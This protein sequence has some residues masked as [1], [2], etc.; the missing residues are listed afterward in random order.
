MSLRDLAKTALSSFSRVTTQP[1]QTTIEQVRMGSVVARLDDGQQ[2]QTVIWEFDD[3]TNRVACTCGASYCEH[4]AA[5]LVALAGDDL[6]CA[7]ADAPESR[8]SAPPLIDSHTVTDE[9]IIEA[10]RVL[11]GETSGDGVVGESS[12]RDDALRHTLALLQ[13]RDLPG[14]R[15]AVGLLR[16]VITSEDKDITRATTALIHITSS[17]A[18]L[19]RRLEGASGGSEP[20]R[21]RH[22]GRRREEL[23]LMEVARNTQRTPFGERRDISYFL[24]LDERILLRELA[25][26]APGSAPKMSE[27]PFP[28]LLLGNLVTIEDGPDPKRV[29]LLQYSSAGY[30]TDGDFEQ[31]L[32]ACDTD[33]A[34]IYSRYSKDCSEGN[35]GPDSLVLYAPDRVIRTSTGV[36]FADESGALLPLA[37]SIAPSWCDTVDLISH[38]GA[39]L[40]VIGPIVFHPKFLTL[41]P[42]SVLLDIGG[43]KSLRRIK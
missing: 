19:G 13:D 32:A 29:R 15:R 17:A 1:G 8:E 38:Q 10:A 36:V 9:E 14:L 35:D 7:D 41:L 33:V 31:L 22:D 18:R 28:K 40:A 2:V 5:L 20:L 3:S 30:A 16:R 21:G 12:E 4:G 27:G 42:L 26:A 34:A 11:V 6:P 25:T 24:D 43:R 23:R 37:R 39:I